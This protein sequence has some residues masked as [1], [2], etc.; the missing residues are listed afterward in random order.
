MSTVIVI[1][2]KTFISSDTV[3]ILVE[4]PV[5]G[6]LANPNIYQYRKSLESMMLVLDTRSNMT[7]N[8]AQTYIIII[9]PYK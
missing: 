6:I 2:C 7:S 8:M 1:L 4:I 3:C 5:N 9:R